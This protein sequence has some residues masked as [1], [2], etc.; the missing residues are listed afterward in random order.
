MEK[1]TFQGLLVFKHSFLGAMN[2]GV[3]TIEITSEL[4]VAKWVLGCITTQKV[5]VEKIEL[6]EEL[7]CSRL[8]F[9]VAPTSKSTVRSI[10]IKNEKERVVKVL[11]DFGY[12]VEGSTP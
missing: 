11:G 10:V 9:V 2:G 1:Y 12:P 6:Q 7:L 3:A 5:D 8:N 4:L